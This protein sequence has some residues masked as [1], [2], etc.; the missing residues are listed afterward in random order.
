MQVNRAPLGLPDSALHPPFDAALASLLAPPR[1]GETLAV[2]L[3]GGIDSLALTLLTHR[4]TQRHGLGMIAVTVD[5][6]VRAGARQEAETVAEWMRARGIAHR[7]LTPE[8]DTTSTNLQASARQR[9][10]DAIATYCR[11]HGI[12]HCLLGHQ[13]GDNR[14]TLLH[15]RTRGDTADGRAGMARVRLHRGVRF[16]RPL[17]AFER[18]ALETYMRA[19]HT[20][21]IEDPSNEN[22]AFARVRHRAWLAQDA[23]THAA[24]NAEILSAAQA[25]A[26]RDQTLAEAAIHCVRLDPLGFADIDCHYL[27]TL[28]SLLASQLLADTIT[29]VSGTA[30]RPR[31][32][33][34]ERL[35]SA[36]N[37]PLRRHTL[38]Q[39]DILALDAS[40]WRIARE[41]RKVAAPQNLSGHG[42][43]RWDNR[44]DIR[45]ALDPGQHITIRALG[46]DGRKQLRAHHPLP[47]LPLPLSTPSLWHLDSLLSVPYIMTAEKPLT[48]RMDFSPAKALA[49]AP[50][51]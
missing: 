47:H 26:T 21:W 6:G 38:H 1:A 19:S 41:F 22:F 49:A 2:A 32:L 14:E 36:L 50:F 24:L 44:F 29:T 12:V 35:M 13:A 5:H 48:L 37:Q 11:A 7:I 51:W 30:Y 46:G 4:Y 3:S 23:S 31:A 10:Y 33:S 28:P 39:C 27:R 9:R 17:L 42:S 43:I 16:L 15:N 8:H 20:P 25:R 40:H 34:I 45:Y 18:T